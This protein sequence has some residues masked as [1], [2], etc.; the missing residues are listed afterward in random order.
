[1]VGE[2]NAYGPTVEES[3]H[4][5]STAHYVK[6]LWIKHE[7]TNLLTTQKLGSPTETRRHD[8]AIVRYLLDETKLPRFLWNEVSSTSASLYNQLLHNIISMETP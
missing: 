1:M 8:T 6:D 2:S 5:S 7:I 4:R 3:T